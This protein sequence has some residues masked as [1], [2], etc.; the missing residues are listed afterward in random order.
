MNQL[1]IPAQVVINCLAN[2]KHFSTGNDIEFVNVESVRNLVVWCCKCGA[3]LVHISTTSVAG[4]SIN[5]EPDPTHLYTEQE[6]N[7]GQTLDNQYAQAKYDAERLILD[8]ILHHGLSGK[9]LR[10]GN[11]SA[12]NSDG[13]F[14]ANFQSNNFMATLRAYQT[15]GVCP[16]A[17]LDM[18]CEF[19][20]IDEVADA[21]IRLATTP[22]PCI[23]FH[24]TN[25]HQQLLGDV[26]SEIQIAGKTIHA[27]EK[28]EF[29][30]VMATAMENESLIDR[31]RPLM[32]YNQK[33]NH[34]P[35]SIHATNAYTTQVLYRLGFRWSVTSWDYV[36][37]F[38]RAIDGLGYFD[39]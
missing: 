22:Q 25:P 34:A 18:P 20:P 19:S 15:L 9:I 2:V 13:E 21:V 6:F 35:R 10:V 32:A 27:V 3:R 28:E 38:I 7:I 12:R 16:Y 24:P 36:E 17:A 39:N 30:R 14:Q 26:L 11:L 33:G 4:R 5:G 8:A 1:H 37:Q 23:I 31:L 29:E